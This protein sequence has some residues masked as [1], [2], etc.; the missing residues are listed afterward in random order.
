M[1]NLCY[2][3]YNDIIGNFL[4]KSIEE[5]IAMINKITDLGYVSPS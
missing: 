2:P 3:T 4:Y 5:Q 1:E